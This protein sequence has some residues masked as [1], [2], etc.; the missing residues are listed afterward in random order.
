[1]NTLASSGAI[2]CELDRMRRAAHPEATVDQQGLVER[3]RKGDRDAFTA[4]IDL[5]IAR[6]DTAA[7]LTLRDPDLAR[8]AVQDAL[9]RAWRNLPAL[10]DP[11]RF[12]AWLYRLTINA[13]RW[14]GSGPRDRRSDG[15]KPGGMDVVT[16]RTV[17]RLPAVEPAGDTGGHRRRF[18]DATARAHTVPGGIPVLAARRTIGSSQAARRARRR[19]PPSQSARTTGAWSARAGAPVARPVAGVLAGTAIGGWIAC[20]GGGHTLP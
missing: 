11:E 9:V 12:D 5:S 17:G 8:D 13:G 18:G 10:R 7:R 20:V 1:M 4:L 19:R 16:R 2:C 6:L 15:R 14:V 3:A